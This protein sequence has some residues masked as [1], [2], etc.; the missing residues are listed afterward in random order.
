MRT[1]ILLLL[2]LNITCWADSFTPY[3]AYIKN[4]EDDDQPVTV[5]KIAGQNWKHC[6]VGI[7]PVTN[8]RYCKDAVGWPGKDA[9]IKVVGESIKVATLD[10]VDDSPIEEEYTRIEFEYERI[11]KKTGEK[12]LQSG[13]GYIET[14][15]LSKEK[16][17]GFYSAKNSVKKEPCENKSNPQEKLKNIESSIKDVSESIENLSL[18]KKA[19]ALAKSVGFCPLKPPNEYPKNLKKDVNVYDDKILP[20]LKTLPV[21]KITNEQN[22]LI[23]QEEVIQIDTLSRTLYGEMAKCYRRGLEYPMAVAK[24]IMNRAENTSRHAEFIKPPH[25]DNKP[26]L[27]KVCTSPSQFSMW[28]KSINGQ[29]NKP[30]H[31]G[32]CP[33]IKK[34]APF[35]HSQQAPAAEYDIWKNTVRIATEAILYPKKFKKRTSEINGYFYTSG[36]G[37]FFNMK[38]Q[39]P[40]IEGQK[41]DRSSCLEIWKE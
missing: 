5:F 36:V 38:Q 12:V 18:E 3:T 20:H 30:L 17:S 9:K 41:I 19:E 26:T 4:L 29:P 24:M 14:S 35:W 1:F 25:I 34:D 2:F 37:K 21:P 8:T 23:T 15:Y 31:H 28:L 6:D 11:N 13:A 32:L 7:D 40:K 22:K 39:F 16:F 27:S 33:P 10:P